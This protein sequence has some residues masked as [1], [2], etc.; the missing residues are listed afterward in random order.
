[1]PKTHKLVVKVEVDGVLIDVRE[2][3]KRQ[4]I[5]NEDVEWLLEHI[6]DTIDIREAP[7]E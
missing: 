1:M 7:D 3:H 5:C 2:Q 6:K 4:W